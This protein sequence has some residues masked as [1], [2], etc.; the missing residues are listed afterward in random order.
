MPA[1]LFLGCNGQD[2]H[3]GS[4]ANKNVC[5]F[6][7][8]NIPEDFS[9]IGDGAFAST[10]DAKIKLNTITVNKAERKKQVEQVMEL[11]EVKE[12]ENRLIKYH[13]T[14][15]DRADF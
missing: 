11:V 14:V 1:Y 5:S 3:D 7:H 13:H 15:T 10:G 4:E 8:L 12:Y 2:G 9:E 6:T